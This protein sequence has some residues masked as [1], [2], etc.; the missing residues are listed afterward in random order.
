LWGKQ[1][2]TKRSLPF[3]MS[4]LMGLSVSSLE[5]CGRRQYAVHRSGGQLG[6]THLHLR[7]G[8]AGHL[9]DHVED[10]LLLIGKQRDVVPWRDELAVLLDEDA[11]LE[12]IG[13]ANCACGVGHLAW[14]LC[15][16]VLGCR[17]CC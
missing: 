7:I 10:R 1:L 9:D 2:R 5:I 17:R 15:S 16:G 11:V 8:P 14:L 4:C 3:L 13:R 12:R 6:G